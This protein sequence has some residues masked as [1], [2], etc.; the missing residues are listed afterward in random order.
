MARFCVFASS[1]KGNSSY[2]SCGGASILIDAGISCRR[3]ISGI[4]AVGDD[5][6]DLDAVL[7]T[8]EHSDHINGLMNLVK[9]T[10]A[11]VFATAPVLEYIISHSHLPADAA[12]CEVTDRPFEIKGVE[13]N[14]FA[15]PHDSIDSVG[16]RFSLA[17]GE[18]VAV[19]TDLGHITEAVR[20]GVLGCQT[21]L[22]ESNYDEQ[23]L[24]IGNYP[25][26]L[27]QRIN[28]DNGHL[29]NAVSARFAAELVKTGTT[30]LFLGHLSRENNTPSL[31]RQA[32]EQSLCGCG[33]VSGVD[34]QLEVAPYDELSRIARF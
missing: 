19:A 4:T 1:S 31:A 34:F 18:E 14:A 32:A 23:L 22:L 11:R 10:G 3:I 26:F 21:V 20:A 12:V 16:Y 9:K 24:K 2:L 28:S 8:H 33:A 30:R 7:I 5:F 27:K 25:C 6:R 17:S 29:E 13:V 15:T